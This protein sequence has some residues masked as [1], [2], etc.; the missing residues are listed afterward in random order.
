MELS[1]L[2]VKQIGTMFIMILFGYILKKCRILKFE[3]SK[4]LSLLALYLIFPCVIFNSFLIS[5]SQERM[6]GLVLAVAASIGVHI[7]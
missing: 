5:Y 7:L 4:T 1:I 2:L 6:L 3:D